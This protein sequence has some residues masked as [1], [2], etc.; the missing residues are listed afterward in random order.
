MIEAQLHEKVEAVRRFDRFYTNRIGLLKPGLLKT[1][2]PLTQARIIFELAQR[3]DLTASALTRTLDI[4]AGYLSR[5]LSAFE[6]DGLIQKSPSKS[7]NRH[8]LLK[9]TAKGRK[10]FSVLNER[11][12]RKNTAL[13]QSLS[14]E[15]QQ[16][17]LQAMSTLEG[18][19]GAQAKPA[20]PYLLRP[21]RPGDIGWI[22]HRHGVLYAEEYG[23]DE[24]FEALVADI[25]ARFIQHHD[26]KREY[27]W[28]AE[29]D[30]ERVG[31]ILIVDAGEEVAQLRILLVEPK[32]RGRGI[33]K[34]L[35]E[36]CVD[37][38]KRAGYKKIKL[39]TQSILVA[40]RHLY[41]K[42]GF[43]LVEEKPHRSFGRDLVAQIWELPL[44]K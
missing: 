5:I 34:R 39:W 22:I 29:Q 16:R 18:L 26:P 28:I 44:R 4:D 40:A 20:G 1:R 9:L 25:L 15:D 42:A 12:N 36:E 19:L 21:H 14:P 43:T 31:S 37:F 8:R 6:K 13:L 2:F 17:L 41:E 30:G 35:I 38:S 27:L 10:A 32:A 11:S 7:D 33:G 23:F 3:D 24:T